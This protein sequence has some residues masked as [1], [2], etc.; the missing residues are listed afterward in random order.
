MK[1]ADIAILIGILVLSL[2]PLAFVSAGGGEVFVTVTKNGSVVYRAPITRDAVIGLDGNTVTVE[3]GRVYMSDADC[4][5]RIC[6]QT[7]DASSA[8]PIVCLPN[9]VI[10]TVGGEEAGGLDAIAG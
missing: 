4:P 10:V 6:I 8:R 9:G 1:R 3:H 5:D 7:G 2:L